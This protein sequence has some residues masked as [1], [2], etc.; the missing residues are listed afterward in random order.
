MKDYYAILGVNPDADRETI[1]TVYRKLCHIYHPDKG[2]EVSQSRITDIYEAYEVLSDPERRAEYDRWYQRV[3]SDPSDRK[4][5]AGQQ[6]DQS[7]APKKGSNASCAE[8]NGSGRER[9]RGAGGRTTGTETSGRSREPY[10][11]GSARRSALFGWPKWRYQ[12][13][14]MIGGI[15][16]G[17]FLGVLGIVAKVP[18][19]ALV[20]MASAAGTAYA[21]V[22]TDWLHQLERAELGAILVG[23]ASLVSTSAILAITAI[24]LVLW[25]VGV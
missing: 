24:Y 14:L 19:F 16:T 11:N 21:G 17:L 9:D 22:K 12:R 3:R 13:D 5:D 4:S 6:D 10:A 1:R 8:P 23:Q 15:P 25:I 20:G 18:L 2:L 7:S